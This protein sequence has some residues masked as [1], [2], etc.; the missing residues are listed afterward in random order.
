MPIYSECAAFIWSAPPIPHCVTF[1]CAAA[2][3]KCGA[4][5]EKLEG[6]LESDKAPP[7][8]REAHNAKKGVSK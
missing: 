2:L 6:A 1:A 7:R 8:T 4:K 5:A 3:S